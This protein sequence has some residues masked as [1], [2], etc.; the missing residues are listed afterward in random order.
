M[1]DVRAVQ[2]VVRTWSPHERPDR[3]VRRRT[4]EV[5]ILPG[6]TAA[7]RLI[8][9]VLASSTRR[10]SKATAASDSNILVRARAS[11]SETAMAETTWEALTPA[12]PQFCYWITW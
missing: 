12:P 2:C 1:R 8:D 3:E 4:D 5:G 10:V 9:A 6:R 11:S 7:T